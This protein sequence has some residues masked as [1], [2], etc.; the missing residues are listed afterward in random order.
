M[1]IVDMYRGV[2]QEGNWVRPDSFLRPRVK[3]NGL[4]NNF[5]RGRIWRLRHKDLQPGE[6]PHMLDETP[7]Q[8]VAHLDHPNGWWRDTAQKLLVIKGDKSVVPALTEMAKTSKEHLGRIHALWTLEGLDALDAGLISTAL[9]DAHPQVRIA[10]IRAGEGL[11]KTHPELVEQIKAMAADSD[12]DVEVQVALTAKYL[13]WPDFFKLANGIFVNSKF[14]GTKQIV[15]KLLHDGPS[16]D[17]NKFNK[18]D[19][20]RLEHGEQIFRELCYSCHGHDGK[21]MSKDMMPATVKVSGKATGTTIAPSLAGSATVYDRDSMLRVLMKGLTGP[22]NAKTYDAEMIAMES[23]SDEWVAD[24]ASY[25]RNSFGNRGSMV[26]WADSARIR[27][28]TKERGDKKWTQDEVRA[29][30]PKVLISQAQMETDREPQSQGRGQC[31]RRRQRHALGYERVDGARD[32]VP[33]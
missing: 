25:V 29:L 19:V 12:P 18:T 24:V 6:W 26:T 27:A 17:R 9:K 7:A 28:E 14:D 32:V 1:Y 33:D 4:Q 16:F 5:G 3:Q 22:V 15:A 31:H 8:L 30:A 20:A 23:N 21:G 2:I 10:A 11:T 13:K